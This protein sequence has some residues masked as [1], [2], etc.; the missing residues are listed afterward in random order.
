MQ[1][2]KQIDIGY[3]KDL[4][5]VLTKKEIKVRYKNSYLGYLW[6]LLNPLG[7]AS[8]FY[9]VFNIV[10]KIEIEHHFLFLISGLFPWQWISNSMVASTLIFIQNATI[11]KKVNFPRSV[12]PLA[13][14]LQDLFNFLCAIPIIIFFL[15]ISGLA[16]SF[17][18]I[19]GIPLLL[20]ITLLFVY[21]ISLILSCLNL[22]FRDIQ[23]IIPILINFIFYLTPILYKL[24]MVPEQYRKL[25]LIN[26]IAP[27]IISWKKLFIQ[28][29]LIP[30]YL[31]FSAIYSIVF[32]LLGIITYK[33]LKWKFGEVL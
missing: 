26:P 5:L 11:I 20:I 31:L 18:W 29:I 21:G 7:F 17:S 9:F 2:L 13:N 32:L 22:F 33:K 10:L 24:E 12:L 1:L 28:G 3:Y 25:L 8:I 30:E 15:L 4:L 14:N 16:P 27:I 23:Q 6:S 19:Y